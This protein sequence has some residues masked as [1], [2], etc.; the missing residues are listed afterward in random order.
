MNTRPCRTLR[1]SRWFPRALLI[2]ATLLAT[3]CATSTRPGAVGIERSQFLAVPAATVEKMA[4][5]SY[6]E[7]NNKAK[8][9]GA[10]IVGGPIVDRLRRI[11]QR[12]VPQ[13]TVFRDDALN[14]KWQLAVIES[15][16]LNASCAPG[17][18]I[19]FYTG[20]IQ[21]LSLTDDEIAAVMG[22]EIAHALREHGRERISQA[23]A[24][25]LITGVALAATNNREAE[26]ALANQFSHFLFE[27]PH[28]RLEETEADQIGL[29][30]AARA[31][32]DPR[33][34]LS[35]WRKMEAAN[36]G[37]A[38][39]EFLSTH[40]SSGHRQQDIESLLPTVMPLY[41]QAKR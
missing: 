34:A 15:P 12:L 24:Q 26:I 1:L 41:Q 13:T 5:L 25:N 16:E 33:A 11:E 29:E 39:P 35:L 37:N 2:G 36:K 3:A 6:A 32:Y 19:T 7:Q 14:W 23:Y 31:G 20:L 8:S 9:A 28:S 40:P 17:G 4:A 30:L 21:Q 18:K 27:L 10:L 22:H 38:P